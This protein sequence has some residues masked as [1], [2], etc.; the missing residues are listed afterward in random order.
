MVEM[1][2]I[3]LLVKEINTQ[4]AVCL[5]L[6]RNEGSGIGQNKGEGIHLRQE[7]RLCGHSLSSLSLVKWQQN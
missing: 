4:L 1:S 3:L 7:M 6:H 2:A 5:T